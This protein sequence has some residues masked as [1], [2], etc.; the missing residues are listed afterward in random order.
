MSST[1]LMRQDAYNQDCRREHKHRRRMCALY[2]LGQE[3]ANRTERRSAG[4][5]LELQQLYILGEAA[6]QSLPCEEGV[7]PIL[8]ALRHSLKIYIYLIVHEPLLGCWQQS[9]STKKLSDRED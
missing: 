3:C 8:H 1:S 7:L 9:S 2:A 6:L 5:H 4:A